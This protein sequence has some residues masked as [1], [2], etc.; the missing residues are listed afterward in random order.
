MPWRMAPAWPVMPP[1][2]TL[3]AISNWPCSF[4]ASSG[5]RTI[6]RPVSRPKNSSSGRSLTVMLSGAGLQVH[7]GGGG[8]AAA[9]A[10]VI[11]LVAGMRSGPIGCSS[12][13]GC[14]AWCGCSP[15]ANTCS[16]LNMRRPSGFFGS[17]PLTANSIA[18]SGC[19]SSSFSSAIDLMPPMYAGVVVVDLVGELA[20]GDADLLAL[21]H[22]D[23]IA[24]VHV[25]A[26]VS[27]VLA[28]EAMRDLRGQAPERLAAGVDDEP[29]AADGR[30]LG[31]YG[32]HKVTSRAS[33]GGPDGTAKL[34]AGA[35][36]RR[37]SVLK[38]VCL[39]KGA[40]RE[41]PP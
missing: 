2:S 10:V 1:P 36:K 20:A 37:G 4:T 40:G 38:R 33:R 41:A 30:R 25:R 17:M 21:H 31:E 6:M 26:V 28:L 15:P 24:H 8:L 13:L 5:W 14:C 16:F 23:V 18:R 22:D 34:T 19:S 9:G 29:V 3:T 27:L 11:L 7:A 32:L 35:K 12:G 39:C